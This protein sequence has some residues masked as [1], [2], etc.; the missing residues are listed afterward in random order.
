MNLAII[1]LN[2]FKLLLLTLTTVESRLLEQARVKPNSSSY[3]MF[4]L[5]MLQIIWIWFKGTAKSVRVSENSSY[6]M[7]ELS[8]FY[9]IDFYY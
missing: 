3:R 9:S 7:L 4:E 6:R 2:G 8:G 5:S 1:S